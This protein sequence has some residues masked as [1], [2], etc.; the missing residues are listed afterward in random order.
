M[1]SHKT[2]PLVE[3]FPLGSWVRNY[4]LVTTSCSKHICQTIEQALTMPQ[5]VLAAEDQ[6]DRI[7][8]NDT[9]WGAWSTL[10]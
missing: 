7:A 3:D 10:D 1:I 2:N 6:V 5:T 9:H 4:E 8:V